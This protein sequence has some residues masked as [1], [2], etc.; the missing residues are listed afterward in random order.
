MTTQPTQS[1]QSTVFHTEFNELRAQLPGKVLT[2]RDPEWEQARLP[3]VVNVD[4]HPRAIVLPDCAEDIVTVVRF[5]RG[6][7]MTV[8]AQPGGHG[9]TA[10]VNDTILL[11]TRGLTGI[12][13]DTQHRIARVGAGV[14]WGELLTALEGTGLTGLAGSTPD[15]TVVGLSVGGGMS[16]FGRAYGLASDSIVAL[17][18]VDADG[19]LVRV[20]A[21]TDPD[22]FWAIR[23]GGGDFGIITAVEVRLHPAEQ[24]YG[25]RLMWTIEHAPAV[26]RAFQQVTSSAPDELTVWFHILRFPPIED[27]PEPLRGGQFVSFDLTFLGSGEDAERLIAPVRDT[28]PAPM[29]D[30]M[31]PVAVAELGGILQEPLDPTPAMER[32][33]LLPAL[34]DAAADAFLGAVGPGSDTMLMIAQLRHLGGA[35][36][37]P[38]AQPGAVGTLSE[39]YQMFLLGIPAVAELVPPLRASLDAA[40]NAM[41]PFVSGRKTF[42]FLGAGQD[43]SAAYTP[44]ALARLRAIKL[45]RDPAGVIRSNRPVLTGSTA[46]PLPEQ[47]G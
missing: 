8:A 5:A 4:Q 13:I 30:S 32:S 27:I 36:A 23:G 18:V 20:T 34:T 26:L 21:E 25:G 44:A 41:V 9:S 28:L 39:Q 22:L 15:T 47:R 43:P 46:S 6:R 14:K 10:A 24:V 2:P 1:S 37:R 33:G 7:G 31:G 17:D 42:N 12:S 38:S 35:L 11:R 16:W 3:W 29:I 19:E 40:E 45:E